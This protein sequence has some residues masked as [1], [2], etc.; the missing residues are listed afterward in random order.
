MHRG[1]CDPELFAVYDEQ[2]VTQ[3]SDCVNM[4]NFSSNGDRFKI[5]MNIDGIDVNMM[6][7]TGASVSVISFNIYK[8]KFSKFKLSNSNVKLYAFTGKSLKVLGEIYVP[9]ENKQT[10]KY[11]P[12][13]V[14]ECSVN[15]PILLG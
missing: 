12:L 10:C 2:L 7:D 5:K 6:I 1:E 11:L 9:V 3:S 8:E 4:I 14:V 13:V 15:A